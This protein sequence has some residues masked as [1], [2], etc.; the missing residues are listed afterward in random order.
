MIKLFLFII[1]TFALATQAFCS[2]RTSIIFRKEQIAF[3]TPSGKSVT[4]SIMLPAASRNDSGRAEPRLPLLLVFGGFKGAS[5]VLELL[6]PD[7]PIAIT[8]FDYPFTPPR[9]FVFPESLKFAPEAKRAIN[10]MSEAIPALIKSLSARQDLDM[11]KITIIGASFGAP[12]ALAAAANEGAGITGIVLI[13]GFGDVPGTASHQLAKNWESRLGLF[14]HPAAWLFAK[15]A[16]L[17]LDCADPEDSARALRQNQ[18]VLVIS[19]ENDSFIPAKS[20]ERLLHSL[21]ESSATIETLSMPGDHI[22]PGSSGLLKTISNRVSN[23]LL[24][25]NLR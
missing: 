14:A 15:L 18:R 9:K 2:D 8:S 12:F 24:K 7:V 21:E 10:E 5:K 17:Y 13:H 20:K 19:A 16:W 4:A 3:T 25:Q 11:S 22:Q 6:N 23:W 1:P